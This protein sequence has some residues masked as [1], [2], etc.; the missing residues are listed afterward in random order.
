MSTDGTPALPSSSVHQ[1]AETDASMV[2]GAGGKKEPSTGEKSIKERVCKYA[3][4]AFKLI[5][6][7]SWTVG[8]YIVNGPGQ[9]VAGGLLVPLGSVKLADRALKCLDLEREA[10]WITWI[11]VCVATAAAFR[12]LLWNGIYNCSKSPFD[13]IGNPT[14]REALVGSGK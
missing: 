2:T 13:N 5:K 10:G 8:K 4:D 11:G 12:Y 1:Q 9:A 7:N 6:T 14:P 3:C